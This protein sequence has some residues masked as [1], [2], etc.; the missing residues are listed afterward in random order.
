MLGLRVLGESKRSW[1]RERG[2]LIESR[3]GNVFGN[4]YCG[5][6]D[7]C[8]LGDDLAVMEMIK[9]ASKLAKYCI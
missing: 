2:S 1:T 6:R 5:I 4:C 8:W 7:A 3:M 9:M